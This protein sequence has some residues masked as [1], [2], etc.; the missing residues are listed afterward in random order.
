MPGVYLT[1]HPLI[2]LDGKSELVHQHFVNKAHVADITGLLLHYKFVR[3]F[4]SRVVDAVQHRQYWNDSIEYQKYHNVLKDAPNASL[5]TATAH[6]LNNVN[7]LID[8]QFIHVSDEYV[9]L[10][11]AR[12]LQQPMFT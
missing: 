3:G 9:R 10:R 1:K 4:Y 8:T 12:S 5:C 2:F 11:D 6:R 7:E